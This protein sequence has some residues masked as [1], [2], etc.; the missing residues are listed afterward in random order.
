MLK[1]KMR[2]GNFLELKATQQITEHDI[3]AVLP[4]VQDLFE[5]T[6]SAR[7]LLH[8]ADFKGWTLKGLMEDLKFTAAH[9]KDFDKV[10]VVGDSKA[11]ELLATMAKPLIAG[12]V[13]YYS[14][15][16]EESE[17]RK[18]LQAPPD[19]VNAAGR[20]SFPASDPA[21]YGSPSV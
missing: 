2:Q 21:S 6:D 10:A 20:D 3:R 17:A 11:H 16:T 9:R 12:S 15:E 5:H 19:P 4:Q 18:W 1:V 14:A 8:V 13:R 7:V